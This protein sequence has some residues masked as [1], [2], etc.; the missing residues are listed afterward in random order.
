M[1]NFLLR[2]LLIFCF[3]F[4]SVVATATEE[5]PTNVIT[6]TTI[7]DDAPIDNGLLWLGVAGV[8][9]GLYYYSTQR[10]KQID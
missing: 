2:N 3:L 4:S 1:K 8:A 7:E 10:K 5:D 9:F 6:D